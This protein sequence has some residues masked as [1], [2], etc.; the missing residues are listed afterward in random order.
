MKVESILKSN[1]P[2]TFEQLKK[3]NKHRQKKKRP[4]K[5]NVDFEKLMQEA[6]VY[7]KSHGAFRQVR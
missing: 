3:R 5:E 4:K 2:D 1:Y 6:P 7:K